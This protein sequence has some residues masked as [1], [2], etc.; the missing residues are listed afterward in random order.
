MEDS[1]TSSEH[2]TEKGT[3]MI[4]IERDN[5][6][7]ET[8]ERGDVDSEEEKVHHEKHQFLNDLDDISD[9]SLEDN[10]D[11]SQVDF[12]DTEKKMTTG[13]SQEYEIRLREAW[14]S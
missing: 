7:D 11:I 5:S 9:I 12:S 2:I 1:R 4:E 14:P 10:S 6:K 13:E 3:R 8:E